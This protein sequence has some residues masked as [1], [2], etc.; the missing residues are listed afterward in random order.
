MVF[1]L[2]GKGVK[3]VNVPYRLIKASLMKQII[4]Q[5]P[6]DMF[7]PNIIISGALAKSHLPIYNHLIPCE[8]RKTGAPSL[9]N[10]MKLLKATLKSFWQTICCWPKIKV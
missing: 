1:L 8:G 10:M 3:D 9:N 6:A 4:E 7:V 2:F 5:I